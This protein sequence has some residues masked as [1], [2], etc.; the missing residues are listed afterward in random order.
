MDLR[1]FVKFVHPADTPVPNAHVT[2]ND[3]SNETLL[4][5]FRHVPIDSDEEDRKDGADI[6]PFGTRSLLRVLRTCKH[7]HPLAEF[8]LYERIQYQV[9]R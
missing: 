8:V 1:K 7:F 6:A 9:R 3:I 2:I 5:I 4:R